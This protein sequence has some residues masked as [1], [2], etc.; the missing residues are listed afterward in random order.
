MKETLVALIDDISNIEKHFYIPSMPAGAFAVPVE[1]I[2]NSQEF[3]LWRQK[4]L[5]ELH[6]LYS[7]HDKDKFLKGT[8][9]A[10]TKDFNTWQERKD[11]NNLKAKLL[12][13]LDNIDVYY[14][15]AVE[16]ENLDKP[17]MI[18]ISHSTKDKE[19]A[20]A[21]VNL[22]ESMGLDEDTVFCSSVPGYDVK[23]GNDIY[24]HLRNLFQTRDL[25][26][27]Y[28]LSKNFYN[29]PASLNEMGAAWVL[30]NEVTS[31]L[32]PG[33]SFDEM[34]GVVD[35][36][37]IAIKLDVDEIELKDKLNQLYETIINEF[38]LKKKS[39]T[40]WECKR[41]SFIKRVVGIHG[42]VESK[43]A[44]AEILSKEAEEILKNAIQSYDAQI[45]VA[46]YITGGK[47][48]QVGCKSYSESM[49]A[50]EFSKWDAAFDEL[51]RIGYVKAIGT[52]GSVFQVT[53]A[54]FK[55]IEEK[56]K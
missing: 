18:F 40:L 23:L 30:K 13:I 11:F 54:G 26:I 7:V 32:L 51:L 56:V 29:S 44:K 53:N 49:G 37:E 45:I 35:N 14:A 4:V 34:K 52:K 21:L 17:A 31:I 8:I 43:V 28:M 46:H 48:I 1:Q 27:V 5:R 50:R 15:P 6:E 24:E 20:T 10:L 3:Q 41:D 19:Y 22:F 36:R 39:S 12:A 2:S 38:K 42:S 9:E 25:H 16:K 55:Y 33:F 47:C